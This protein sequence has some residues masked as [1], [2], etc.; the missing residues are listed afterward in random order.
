MLT[1]NF[2][3]GSGTDK[4]VLDCQGSSN[5]LVI[6][7]AEISIHGLTIKNCASNMTSGGINIRTSNIVLEDVTLENNF[8]LIASG[9]SL[10]D[11]TAKIMASRF[12]NNRGSSLVVTRS[13]LTLADVTFSTSAQQSTSDLICSTSHLDIS[14][15]SDSTS[16]L[17]RIN[18]NECTF[19]FT[20]VPT[21]NVRSEKRSVE[22]VTA[23]TCGNNACESGE[24]CFSCPKDCGCAFDGYKVEGGTGTLS[25]PISSSTFA[26]LNPEFTSYMNGTTGDVFGKAF[27]YFIVE[28]SGDYTFQL[29]TKYMAGEVLID[30][31]TIIS[32]KLIQ[33]SLKASANIIVQSGYIHNISIN[34][35]SNGNYDRYLGLSWKDSD[36]KSDVYKLFDNVF[37][38]VNICGDHI[39]DD[40]IM[41]PQDAKGNGC[42]T[43]ACLADDIPPRYTTVKLQNNATVA[44]MCAS[45]SILSFIALV[46]CTN[47]TDGLLTQCTTTLSNS[48]KVSVNCI[49]VDA[50][51]CM[52][53]SPLT[54]G[55]GICV[56]RF[57]EDCFVDCYDHITTPCPSIAP[58][59]GHISPGLPVRDDTFGNLIRN[60]MLWHLPGIEHVTYGF[61]IIKG[62]GATSPLFYF[63]YCSDTPLQTVQ[64]TY[65]GNV[66]T[67]PAEVYAQPAPR[68]SFSMESSTYSSSVQMANEMTQNTGKHIIFGLVRILFSMSI[69]F[70]QELQC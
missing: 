54:C 21:K 55:T 39:D 5:A 63:G 40:N 44:A 25:S 31:K 65:R 38:S 70:S 42:E 22:E 64:D 20:S 24:D 58:P 43:Y 18:S 11:S 13:K 49:K 66:Y 15:T 32:S 53:N 35:Y 6:I 46:D 19:G 37:Y 4:T 33:S 68:C 45:T 60:Q 8:G 48:T 47:G 57:A 26:S 28:D 30:G 14:S 7:D 52:S 1:S 29:S 67:V 17:P 27:A 50:S 10:E 34:F 36:N 61:D 23:A 3:S 9:V 56:E 2:F 69:S 62:E 16:P 12:I 51:V 41:C 59:V